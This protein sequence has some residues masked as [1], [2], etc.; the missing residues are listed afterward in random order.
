MLDSLQ[1]R[2]ALQARDFS[3][4]VNNAHAIGFAGEGVPHLVFV[5]RE[6]DGGIER[7]IE[8]APLVLHP[9]CENVARAA[10]AT[11]SGISIQPKH[12][13]NTNLK[14][15][16]KR[17]NKGETETAYGLAVGLRDEAALDHLLLH[18]R[19]PG[20]PEDVAFARASAQSVEA[21]K[22]AYLAVEPQMTAAQRAMLLG[23]ARAP[24]HCLSMSAIAE[25][26]GYTSFEAAN[27]QYGRLGAGFAA[28][29]DIDGLAQ[30]TQMLATA[31]AERDGQ[32][33]WQW[34]MR[35]QLVQA[36]RELGVLDE[37]I[38]ESA[39]Q[40]AE[41]ELAREPASKSIPET[42]R[43]ALIQA[44]VGQGAYRQQLL[45][46]WQYRCALSGCRVVQALVASHAKPWK[47]SS[48]DERLDPYNGLLLA[49]S[50]DRLFDRGLI[51]FT[52]DGRLLR[53]P[54]LTEADLASL[55]LSPDARLRKVHPQNLPYL[56][57][58]R[59]RFEFK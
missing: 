44:R 47:D 28:A 25:L 52:D 53:E 54:D 55:G 21:F 49:A 12:Y 26:G 43:Q 42:T 6:Q 24:G 41:M 15:F 50:I 19:S 37:S 34:T 22:Q 17:K 3:P 14:G 13:F 16:P 30:K 38:D 57:A 1:L 32:G 46:L 20:S 31:G 4:K 7:A 48:N 40:A 23:H 59:Q 18:L 51:S 45:S 35:P 58:H 5:K 9:E 33:H 39:Y 11:S 10:A 2:K 36:L 27:T 8:I 29:L 56:A